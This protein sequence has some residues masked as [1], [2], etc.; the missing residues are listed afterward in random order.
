M[1]EE[2]KKKKSCNWSDKGHKGTFGCFYGLTFLG[3]AIY[4]I[5]NAEGFWLGVVAFLKAI[6]WPV[7]VMI[8]ILTRLGL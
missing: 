2:A 4:W 7:F 5:G 1:E 8:E 6:V 3:A